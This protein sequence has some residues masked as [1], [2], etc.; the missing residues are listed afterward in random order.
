MP[1][2]TDWNI[3]IS[4]DDVLRGQGADPQRI[5]ARRPRLVEAAERAM[6]EGMAM[7]SPVAAYRQLLVSAV[8]HERI[9]LEGGA[10][11]SG[12]LVAGMLAPARAV[13]AAVCTIGPAL[14]NLSL[15]YLESDPVHSLALY[16]VGSAA[17]EA[18]STAACQFF[19]QQAAAQ[20]WQTTVPLSPGLEGWPV[21]RGQA[22]VFAIVDEAPVAG[23][24]LLPSS[25]MLPRKTVSLAIGLGPNVDTTAR[26]CDFCAMRHTCRNRHE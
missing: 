18:L 24:S 21:E 5:R 12:P 26:I 9:Q 15:A 17:A 8:R 2:K 19:S 7:L 22:E 11:L 6:E 20:G 13:I 10:L 25:L 4:V 16:G 1:I 3:E 23:V 14:E